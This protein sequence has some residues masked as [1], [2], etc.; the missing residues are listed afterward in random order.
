VAELDPSLRVLEA[1]EQVAK[2]VDLGGGKT[3]GASSLADRFGFTGNAQ[4]TRSAT[5]PAASAGG[6]RSCG[7]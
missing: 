5:C 2:V 1:V 4:W 6:C 7:C 3:I